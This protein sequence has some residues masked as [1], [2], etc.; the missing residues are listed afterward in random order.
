[1][2]APTADGAAPTRSPTGN[3]SEGA[4]CR[5]Q[6]GPDGTDP[7][8]HQHLGAGALSPL[9]RRPDGPYL[10]ADLAGGGAVE[11]RAHQG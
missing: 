4:S 3:A 9:Q 1:M 5:P 11:D 8:T 6:R 10:L 2:P 7:L